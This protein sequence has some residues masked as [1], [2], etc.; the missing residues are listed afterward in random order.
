MKTLIS[1]LTVIGLVTYALLRLAYSAFYDQL[2]LEPEDVGF[3]YG[4]ILSQSITGLA[5]LIVLFALVGLVVI[6]FTALAGI[7]AGLLVGLAAAIVNAGLSKLP[8]G[9]QDRLTNQTLVSPYTVGLGVLAIVGI[10]LSWGYGG[11][12]IVSLVESSPLGSLFSS[13]QGLSSVIRQLPPVVLLLTPLS[14][15]PW[16]AIAW[17][18]FYPPRDYHPIGPSIER[19]LVL[20]GL[21]LVGL[22][23][24][25]MFLAIAASDGAAVS[26]GTAR[27]ASVF[28]VRIAGWGGDPATVTWSNGASDASLRYSHDCLMYLGQVADTVLLYDV[29]NQVTLRIPASSATVALLGKKS[30]C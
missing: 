17:N 1:S 20:I 14:G 23:T 30:S 10:Q 13:A 22:S 15:V 9:L 4:G 25:A 3:G 27:H 18:R 24:V 26:R 29:T 19:M 28:G 12:F 7:T 11:P 5:F 8:R 6:A 16:L 21:V 2:S